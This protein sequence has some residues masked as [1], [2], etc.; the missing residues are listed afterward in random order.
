MFFPVY[1]PL[2]LPCQQDHIKSI[3]TQLIFSFKSTLAIIEFFFKKK[4]IQRIIIVILTKTTRK[5]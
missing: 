3:L 4:L 5:L 1:M 2:D